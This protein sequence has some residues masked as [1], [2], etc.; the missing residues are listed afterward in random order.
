MISTNIQNSQF[1][2]RQ[3]KFH[4]VHNVDFFLILLTLFD[5]QI[6]GENDEFIHLLWKKNFNNYE[7]SKSRRV[8]GSKPFY[9]GHV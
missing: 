9:S 3:P 1:E 2:W 8:L 4:L 7:K 5:A 6:F